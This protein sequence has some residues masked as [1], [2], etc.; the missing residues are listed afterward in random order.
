[1]S[2]ARMSDES[3]VY[4]YYSVYDKWTCCGCLLRDRRNAEY[5][6]PQELI[7]HVE[8][9]RAAGHKVPAGVEGRIIE[10]AKRRELWAQEAQEEALKE[11]RAK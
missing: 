2:F 4:L 8:A 9:H 10:G 7:A 6:T 3:D 11:W 1:M 5:D